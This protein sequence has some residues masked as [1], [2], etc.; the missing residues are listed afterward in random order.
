MAQS[1]NKRKQHN[2]PMKNW[3]N[4]KVHV[5]GAKRGKTR[6]NKIGFGYASDWLSKWYG[7]V[8]FNQS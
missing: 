1:Q 4:K 8:F 6:V 5:T 3:K 7:T 2:E